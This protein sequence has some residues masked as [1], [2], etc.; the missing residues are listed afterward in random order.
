M[1]RYNICMQIFFIFTLPAWTPNTASTKI[2]WN[3]C[4]KINKRV[5]AF[6]FCSKRVPLFDFVF[7]DQN[8]MSILVIVDK[9]PW[10]YP[11]H[12]EFETKHKHWGKFLLSFGASEILFKKFVALFNHR[13]WVKEFSNATKVI[14]INGTNLIIL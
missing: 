9:V 2:S 3:R 12:K 1:R 13:V 14:P 4:C 8:Y 10:A 11:R 6:I 5:R 7:S